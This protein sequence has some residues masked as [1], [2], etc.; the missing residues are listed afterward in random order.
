MR[1]TTPLR[2]KWRRIGNRQSGIGN[3]KARL[4]VGEW[5]FATADC[6][7]PI[8]EFQP[9][10]RPPRASARHPTFVAAH[11]LRLI[12]LLRMRFAI[13][14]AV[15]GLA[16]AEMEFV[17]R[18]IADRPAAHAVVDREHGRV[19]AVVQHQ[20]I[21]LD[22]R[23]G[24]SMRARL[25]LGCGWHARALAARRAGPAGQAQTVH[26]PDHGV[27]GHPAQNPGDLAGRQALGPERLQLVNAF[28]RPPHARPPLA[29][30][31]DIVAMAGRRTSL[32]KLP[33]VLVH[34]N[35]LGAGHA[36]RD[37]FLRPGCRFLALHCRRNVDLSGR[38]GG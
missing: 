18:G 5:Q 26:L 35:R 4:R 37:A 27:A 8:G 13:G 33:P 10:M 7:L 38:N 6:R 36:R 31:Q 22:H 11:L 21:L 30:A 3:R 23:R 2:G 15:L 16:A 32:A 1:W 24:R 9:A 12:G 28:L 17:A 34:K 14:R 20:R 19:A 25:H 29:V